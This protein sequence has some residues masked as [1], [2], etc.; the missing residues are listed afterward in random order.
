MLVEKQKAGL[1]TDQTV[2]NYLV[3]TSGI[4]LKMFSPS[5]NLHHLVSKNLLNFGQSWWG[6]TLENLYEQAWAYHFNAMPANKL[7]RDSDYFIKRAYT[8][9]WEK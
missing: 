1:G 6:D 7:N 4:D 3:Q 8:E 9:L 5:Y 2:I